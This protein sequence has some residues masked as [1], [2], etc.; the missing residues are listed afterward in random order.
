MRSGSPRTV[1]PPRA[2]VLGAGYLG[3][4]IAAE[5]LLLGSEVCVFDAAL[6]TSEHE[7]PQALLDKAIHQVLRECAREGLLELAGVA[8]PASSSSRPWVPYQGEGPRFARFCL[9]VAEAAADA[10]IVI[11]AVPDSMQIKTRVFAEALSSARPNVFLATSTLSIPLA[12]LQDSVWEA[13][14]AVRGPQAPA[15]RV[16]GLRFLV[17]VTFI[18]FVEMTLTADQMKGDDFRELTSLLESWSKSAFQCDVQGAVDGKSFED[19]R[20]EA[21]TRATRR[22]RLDEKTALRRQQ[23]EARLR[24]VRRAGGLALAALRPSDLFDF[25]EETC[26]VCLGE[27]A[28][29]ISVVCGHCVLC[30]ACADITMQQN[31]RCPLCRAR[32]VR[33]SSGSDERGHLTRAQ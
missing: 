29:V 4:R 22:L 18:P 1:G 16:V 13:A 25:V 15:P 7:P 28:T 14:K 21:L 17:P 32:F 10:D 19:N 30:A 24:Q 27:P 33:Q 8:A 11:E 6:A 5:L 12:Q 31:P 2:A 20:S 23:A 26:C 9:S 3:Q